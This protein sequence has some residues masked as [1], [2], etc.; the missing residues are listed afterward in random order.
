[1]VSQSRKRQR[2][3]GFCSS[4]SPHLPHGQCSDWLVSALVYQTLC[5]YNQ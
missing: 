3:E 4:S 2:P 5:V 1:M